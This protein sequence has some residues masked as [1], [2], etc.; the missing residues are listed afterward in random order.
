M[1]PELRWEIEKFE[2]ER[3]IFDKYPEPHDFAA[4]TATIRKWMHGGSVGTHR[5]VAE[6]LYWVE[7][8]K[9]R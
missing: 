3:T 5:L 6:L 9:D 7:E 1:G 8:F 4:K 2:A